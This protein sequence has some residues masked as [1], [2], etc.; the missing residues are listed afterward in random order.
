[1]LHSNDCLVKI[2][3]RANHYKNLINVLKIFKK[4]ILLAKFT[5]KYF[6]LVFFRK[7]LCSMQ[8]RQI[9]AHVPKKSIRVNLEPK[10]LI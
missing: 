2:L 10:I 3:V 8:S 6:E 1:M 7:F 9:E 5:N 4:L